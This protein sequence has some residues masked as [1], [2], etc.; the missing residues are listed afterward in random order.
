MRPPCSSLP[1]Q[2]S[3][4]PLDR[5]RQLLGWKFLRFLLHGVHQD[6]PLSLEKV[7]YSDLT[8]VC[9]KPQLVE[10]FLEPFGM[11]LRQ[12]WPELLQQASLK[13]ELPLGC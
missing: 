6:D 1:C 2:I 13:E 9:L 12:A 3:V 4:L 7:E 11:R 5:N 8:R 10:V